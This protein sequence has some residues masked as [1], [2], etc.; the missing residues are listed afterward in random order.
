[1]SPRPIYVEITIAAPI[2]LLWRL[3]QD[4]E[5]HTRWDL[6]F[7]SITPTEDVPTGARRFSYERRMPGHTIAGTGISIGETSR[8][9]GTRTSALRFT[10]LDRLSPLREGRGYW[11]YVPVDG[12]VRFITGYDYQPGWGRLA[13]LLVRPV[14]GWMTAWSFDALRIWAEHGIDPA[15]QRPWA[16]WRRDRPRASRCIRTPQTGRMTDAPPA[17]LATLE[18]P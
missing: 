13:D 16:L 3:T 2:D 1:M 15:D 8:P 10:T 18:A 12:G 14:I 17:T 4:P 11:R 9:G 5:L 6:R 7:S